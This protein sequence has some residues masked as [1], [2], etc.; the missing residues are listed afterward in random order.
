MAVLLPV[1]GTTVYLWKY[2]PSLAASITFAIL[3]F[4][5][6]SLIG[7]RMYRTKTWFCTCFV[8]GC[9]SEPTHSLWRVFC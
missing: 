3:Y 8:V 2:I 9:L 4:A 6:C 1:D 5:A 7:I